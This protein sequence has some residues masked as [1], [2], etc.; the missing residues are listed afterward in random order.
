MG[1]DVLLVSLTDD[2]EGSRGGVGDVC[3]RVP[4]QGRAMGHGADFPNRDLWGPTLGKPLL[5]CRIITESDEGPGAASRR[6][7]GAGASAGGRC[8]SSGSRIQSEGRDK[9]T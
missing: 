7:D 8:S 1:R 2:L 5:E 3:H 6:D 4:V 9:K